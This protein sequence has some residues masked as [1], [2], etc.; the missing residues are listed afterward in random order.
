[1]TYSRSL[2][3]CEENPLR[4]VGPHNLR[5]SPLRNTKRPVQSRVALVV[6]ECSAVRRGL[7]TVR[8]CV[9]RFTLARVCA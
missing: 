6:V 2:C 8:C 5:E 4:A 3:E 9:A 1:M 7:V